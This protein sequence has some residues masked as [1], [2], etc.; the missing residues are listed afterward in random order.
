MLRERTCETI[1]WRLVRFKAYAKAQ[2][3]AA[4]R[5]AA[6][7]SSTAPTPTTPSDR[8]NV[9]VRKRVS[10]VAYAL[11]LC[12]YRRGAQCALAWNE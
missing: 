10:G 2:T 11:C 8:S 4:R 9:S 12:G 5:T 6:A 1:V 7:S 3:A